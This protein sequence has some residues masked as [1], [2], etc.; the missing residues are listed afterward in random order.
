MRGHLLTRRH[1]I[2]LLLSTACTLVAL[3]VTST[4]PAAISTESVVNQVNEAMYRHYLDNLLYTHP[5]D[6]RGFG[7][8]HDLAMLNIH[9]T[10]ESFGLTVTYHPFLYASTTYYNVVAVKQ[11]TTYP[12]DIYIVGAHYDSVNNPGADDNGSGTAGVMELA[13]VLSQYDFESTIIFIAFDREEQGLVGS[14]AYATEHSGDNI[15][16]MISMD[17]IAYDAG[18]ESVDIYGRTASNGVKN[19]LAQAVLDWGQGLDVVTHGSLDASDHAPFEWQGFQACIIIED[20]GNPYYHTQNDYVGQFGYIDYGF[21]TRITRSVC[22]WLV[23]EAGVIDTCPA[24]VDG[25]TSVDV[26]DLLNVLGAWGFCGVSCG[27][28]DIDGNSVVDVSDLLTVLA[29]WGACP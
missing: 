26:T 13:R 11:G 2:V 22:G 16:G 19:T 10:F 21:A 20:W 28:E 8:E 29:D 1:R 5:G 18:A 7:P 25:S 6:D 9:D 3:A 17:M 14:D 23:D 4:A 24:D 27:P 12:D 15:L